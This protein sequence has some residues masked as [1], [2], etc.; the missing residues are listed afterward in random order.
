LADQSA[1]PASEGGAAAPAR[2]TIV[3][4]LG[5]PVL[6]DD[7][8][9]WRIADE[10]EAGLAAARLAGAEFGPVQV[11]RLGVGGLALMES[12]EGFD[13]AILIDA[14]EFPDRPPGEVRSCD[15][16]DLDSFAAGHLDSAHDASLATALELGRQFG[17]KLPARI[18]AV[19]VQALSTG[20]FSEDLT[21]EV[22][23]AVPAATATV[24]ELIGATHGPAGPGR[25]ASDEGH[26]DR[27]R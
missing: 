2:R 1:P 7:G 12:L 24:L 14:A 26:G 9:G 19:T 20:E 3:V 21:P 15:L 11:E 10:V 6:G 5:N 4:G 8:V 27:I 16:E 17:A 25:M 23:A 13:E 18:R 22:E